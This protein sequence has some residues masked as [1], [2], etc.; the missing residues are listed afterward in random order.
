MP[1]LIDED[2]CWKFRGD[3]IPGGNEG[4]FERLSFEF[5]GER[6][7]LIIGEESIFDDG[8]EKLVTFS[9]LQ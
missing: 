9:C 4:L 3:K 6:R 2:I 5:K 8:K 1:I 7:D